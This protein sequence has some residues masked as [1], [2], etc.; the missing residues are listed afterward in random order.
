[1]EEIVESKQG[2]CDDDVS[3]KRTEDEKIIKWISAMKTEK[4]KWIQNRIIGEINE[5]GRLH[6]DMILCNQRILELFDILGKNV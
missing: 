2:N 5:L 4:Q 1:M 3:Q 6:Q